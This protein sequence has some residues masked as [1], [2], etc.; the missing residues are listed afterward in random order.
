MTSVRRSK[1]EGFAEQYGLQGN[2]RLE[3]GLDFIKAMPKEW[4]DE[5]RW[6]M[7]VELYDDLRGAF[8]DFMQA[9]LDTD[10]GIDETAFSIAELWLRP[11]LYNQVDATDGRFYIP[12]RA[13]L[14]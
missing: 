1:H 11:G 2:G 8:Q 3:H 6:A 7:M 14:S 9:V 10:E 4:T 5:Q 13:K 12:A